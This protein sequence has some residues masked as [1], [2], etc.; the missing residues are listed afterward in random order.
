MNRDTTSFGSQPLGIRRPVKSLPIPCTRAP[1]IKIFIADK[2]SQ[3]AAFPP[4]ISLL[5][6]LSRRQLPMLRSE[7]GPSRFCWLLLHPA[8]VV[9][10]LKGSRHIVPY[11][12]SISKPAAALR[13]FR[14]QVACPG[15]RVASRRIPVDLNQQIID[16]LN[17]TFRSPAIDTQSPRQ[18]GHRRP[19]HSFASVFP[20]A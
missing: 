20:T 12:S 17:A 18:H 2:Y 15:T 14:H 10:A 1:R 3:A 9:V 4:G 8:S 16:A 6:H 5:V 7:L 13:D 11:A 19:A